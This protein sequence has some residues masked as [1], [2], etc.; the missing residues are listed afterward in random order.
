VVVEL[1]KGMGTTNPAHALN[2]DTAN[3]AAISFRFLMAISRLSLALT[4]SE[5]A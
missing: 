3:A 5:T 4:K 1:D 2:A